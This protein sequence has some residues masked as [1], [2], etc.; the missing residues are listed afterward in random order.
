MTVNQ[1]IWFGQGKGLRWFADLRFLRQDP[2]TAASQLLD[3][4]SVVYIESIV[5]ST[6]SPA[7][8]SDARRLTYDRCRVLNHLGVDRKAEGFEIES[9]A[10]CQ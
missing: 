1:G 4:P 5:W 2:H 8:P 3:Q 9:H 6:P 10:V 7:M